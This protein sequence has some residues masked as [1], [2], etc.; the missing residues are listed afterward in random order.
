MITEN[1][2]KV[3]VKT[4]SAKTELVRFDKEKQA[5]IIKLKAVPEKGKANKELINFLSKLTGKKATIVS[6]FKSKEKIIELI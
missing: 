3:I 2:F 1:K 4:K 5:Y 6:G